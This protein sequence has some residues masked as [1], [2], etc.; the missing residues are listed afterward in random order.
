VNG[1]LIHKGLEVTVPD[2]KI[3]IDST[4]NLVADDLI[5]HLQFDVV[6]T[7]LK[8]AV[9]H[10]AEAEAIRLRRSQ[11]PQI[12]EMEAQFSSAMQSVVASAVALDALYAKVRP[13]LKKPPPR[14]K[15]DPNSRPP[16]RY[17]T[18]AET[19][20]QVFQLNEKNAASVR[21]FLQKI[22][23]F[24]DYAVHPTAEGKAVQAHPDYPVSV[25][26]R[27][28]QYTAKNA[29][30]AANST[31]WIVLKLSRTA[32]ERSLPVATYMASLEQAVCDLF[33][34]GHP[35]DAST[36]PTPK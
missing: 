12:E 6:P 35:L 24:R 20:R 3:R 11:E 25:E 33:P 22:F 19:L 29:T 5:L 27:F 36:D 23:T 16:A 10:A 30:D 34:E 9:A 32:R 4:G 7:W 21:A 17:A 31:T 18:V 8:L 15:D 26:W 13:F 14:R 28:A 2:F 1:V